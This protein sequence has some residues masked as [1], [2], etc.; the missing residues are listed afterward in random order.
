MGFDSSGTAGSSPMDAQI[1]EPQNTLQIQGFSI[2]VIERSSRRFRREDFH[3][4]SRYDSANEHILEQ[5]WH[6]LCGHATFDLLADYQVLGSSALVAFL[7]TCG[8][9]WISPIYTAKPLEDSLPLE[10]EVRVQ[11]G[12]AYL[13]EVSTPGQ[14]SSDTGSLARGYYAMCPHLVE[15]GDLVV[16][17][18]GYTTPFILRPTGDDF[19][20]VGECYFFAESWKNPQQVTLVAAGKMRQDI[21]SDL[22]CLVQ[23]LQTTVKQVRADLPAIFAHLP[24]VLTH[25]DFYESKILV[26]EDDGR[27]TGITDWAEAEVSQFGL[28]LW[29]LEIVLGTAERASGTPVTMP[30]SHGPSSGESSTSRLRLPH[31]WM[32]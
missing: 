13:C 5:I 19:L 24:F 30:S 3:L 17:L 8:A 32:K 23:S 11:A 1:I 26:D 10:P 20:L 15:K 27:I 2:D 25:G 12:I 21:E 4:S 7:D 14:M 22:D 9:T 28:S 18:M 16:V 6:D 31:C 29:G